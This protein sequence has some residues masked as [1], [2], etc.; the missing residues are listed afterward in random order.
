MMR[1]Q[2]LVFYIP[3]INYDTVTDKVVTEETS[4]DDTSSTV[5]DL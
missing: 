5:L 1:Q 4:T 2:N 3:A